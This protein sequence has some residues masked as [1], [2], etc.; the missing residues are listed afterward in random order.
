M[1]DV[2]EVYHRQ[3]DPDFP[4][5]CLD[6]S[7]KQLLEHVRVP[8]LSAPGRAAR[9]D[10]E[11]RRAGTANIFL[12]VEP[13]EGRVIT[14]CTEHRTRV[15]FAHFLRRLADVEY[16]DAKKVV[17]VLDNLNT[18]SPASLYEAFAPA[19]ARLLAERF[20]IHHTP[21]HGSWLNIAEIQLSVLARQA[22]DQRIE[23]IGRLREVLAAWHAQH[24][25]APVRWR[26]TTDK[27]RIKLHRLYPDLE[28]AA[29]GRAGKRRERPPHAGNGGERSVSSRGKRH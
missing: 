4:L 26:F 18:H 22:L 3:Y 24:P 23:S 6:E 2:L 21:K 17:L 12:A 20:E 10:D 9:V 14:E 5:V 16:P 27:A 11:Y 1:E 8:L 25:A 19:E 7:S 28:L 15:D 13:L 29:A